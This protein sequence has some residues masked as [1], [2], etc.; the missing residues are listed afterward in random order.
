MKLNEMKHLAELSK[1]EFSDAELM[2][3]SKDFESLIELADIAKNANIKG[4]R[5]FTS[6][7]MDDLR[8]DVAKK[9]I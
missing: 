4:E 7:D 6:I 3:L 9:S 5:F 2:N 1:L 8:D